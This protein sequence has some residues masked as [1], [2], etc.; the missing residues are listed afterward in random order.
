MLGGC[1][2]RHEA[3]GL[4][5]EARGMQP[6]SEGLVL[7]LQSSDRF[8]GHDHLRSQTFGLLIHLTMPQ[9]QAVQHMLRIRG[10]DLRVVLR[11]LELLLGLP[12]RH[13]HLDALPQQAAVDLHGG[14]QL[15]LEY[16]DAALDGRGALPEATL[17][18]DDALE[19]LLGMLAVD[20]PLRL[21]I[22]DPA[23]QLPQP[24]RLRGVVPPSGL[25]T[26]RELPG[27]AVTDLA[28]DT[29]GPSRRLG[30]ELLLHARQQRQ[31]SIAPVADV[32]GGGQM[33]FGGVE[34][35][36]QIA[37]PRVRFP[38][39][40]Y[41]GRAAHVSRDRLCAGPPQALQQLGAAALALEAAAVPLQHGL[42]GVAGLRRRVRALH[43]ELQEHPVLADRTGEGLD[44]VVADA[45][46]AQVDGEQHDVPAQGPRQARGADVAETGVAQREALEAGMLLD[47]SAPGLQLVA[48]AANG[49]SVERQ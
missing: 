34:D 2:A 9:L 26:Q 16:E 49:V 43:R 30:G 19:G 28:D 6:P 20:A 10:S 35:R 42:Q 3:L 46:V 33:P 14:R 18:L 7:S 15:I 48:V 32:H 5:F 22:A 12:H 37:K 21:Q 40:R 1:E 25:A 27:N 23:L 39:R 13:L 8:L 29:V 47:A 41:S 44:A 4:G 45:V 31:P 38:D 36:V 24:V 17:E 11:A